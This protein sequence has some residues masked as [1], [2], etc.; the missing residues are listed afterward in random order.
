MVT[1]LALFS[2]NESLEDVSSSNLQFLKVPYYLGCLSLLKLTRSP[3]TRAPVVKYATAQFQR[4]LDRLEAYE[5]ILEPEDLQSLHAEAPANPTARR[6]AKIARA[7]RSKALSERVAAL[8]KRRQ[9][10]L[11]REGSSALE[12]GGDEARPDLP[13]DLVR[14]ANL[15]Q[16]RLAATAALSE[17]ESLAMESSMLER[18]AAM[19]KENPK[20][21]DGVRESIA[22]SREAD[23]AAAKANPKPPVKITSPAAAASIRAKMVA[24]VF[25]PDWNQP[26]MSLEEFGRLELEEAKARE[27]RQAQA[28]SARA[29][30]ADVDE[31]TAAGVAAEDAAARKAR[32]WD[33]WKDAN[34]SD[35]NL[36]GHN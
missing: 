16:L 35:G 36:K 9:R 11:D 19:A 5:G 31:D 34:P 32:E 13:D 1:E 33:D 2:S 21:M 6:D 28:A 8:N 18:I 14:D 22:E 15:S 12:N 24:D 7:K 23:I 25:K 10:I 4:F 30:A 26:T 20:G 29:K 27:T 3:E 17:L